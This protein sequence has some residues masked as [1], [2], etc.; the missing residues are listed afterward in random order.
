MYINSIHLQNFRNFREAKIDFVHPD[1]P[2]DT[3]QLPR[4][5]YPNINLLLGDNGSGKTTLLKAVAMACLGPLVDDAGIPAYRLIRREAEEDASPA[6]SDSAETAAEVYARFLSHKREMPPPEPMWKRIGSTF[7]FGNSSTLE[8][9]TRVTKTGDLERIRWAYRDTREESFWYPIFREAD[10]TYFFIAYGA[11][12]RTERTDRVDPAVRR[13]SNFIRAQRILSLFEE[14]YSLIPLSVWLPG[15]PEEQK[16]SVENLISQLLEG[17]GFFFA[18]EREQGEFIFEK[19]GLKVPFPALSDGYRAYIGWIGD[20]LYHLFYPYL[21]SDNLADSA[22]MIPIDERKGIVMIDEID[23]HLHPSWQMRVLPTL[24]KAL[25]N[26]QFIVTSHSPLVASSLE[27]MNILKM[28][29]GDD[30]AS[31]IERIHEAI[32]GLDADQ[33]LL[34]G[35]F[36]LESTRAE[37]KERRLKELTLLAR[38]GDD[39]A[40]LEFIKEMSGGTEAVR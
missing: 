34:S 40:A 4:P 18:G 30:Q 27:W 33:T 12:R 36:G 14:A 13:S 31:T 17:T 1:Q 8:A 23:L 11:T 9:K 15:I 20:L 5:T 35:F 32:H 16:A 6:N 10:D 24:S 2:F 22:E 3:L 7:P 28:Q 37:S 25:P 38:N 21:V 29:T 26:I 19:N 39:D